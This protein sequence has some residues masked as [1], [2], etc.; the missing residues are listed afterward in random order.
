M[1][2]T[3]TVFGS[4][5]HYEKGGVEVI[6]DSPKRYAFSNVFE[7]ASKSKPYERVAVGTNVSYVIEA[8][9]AEDDS[10]WYANAHDEAALVMDGEVEAHLIQPDKAPAPEGKEGAVQLAGEPK[11][12]K[13]GWIK[14][15]RGHMMLLPAGAAYQ[16]RSAKPG[17]LLIQTMKGDCTVECWAEICQR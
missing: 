14:A 7:V 12:R 9:R 13:M 2:G 3:Q 15:R 16:F 8:V 1:V 6:D 10:P 4:L 11:G 17:V 5:D